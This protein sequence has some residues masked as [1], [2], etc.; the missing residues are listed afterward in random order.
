MH[1][2]QSVHILEPTHDISKKADSLILCQS[3]TLLEVVPEV[4]LLAKLSDDV[5]VITGLVDIQQSHY[6]IV[7][8]FLHDFDL[9]VNVLEVVLVGEDA[10]VDHFHCCWGVI[11]QKTAQ[12]DAGRTRCR[13]SSPC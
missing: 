13:S 9:A 11:G 8:Q 7:F 6:V 10:L 12:I 2:V 1:D 3:S 4:P 5:H